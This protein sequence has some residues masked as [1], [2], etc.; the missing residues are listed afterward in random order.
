VKVT[1]CACVTFTYSKNVKIN[2]LN[3]YSICLTYLLEGI[4]K[5]T[6]YEIS[7]E[8]ENEADAKNCFTEGDASCDELNLNW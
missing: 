7:R 6:L 1:Q 2:T 4:G 8:L 5:T 3:W